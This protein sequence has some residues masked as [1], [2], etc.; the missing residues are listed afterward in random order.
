MSRV[1][2][3]IIKIPAGVQVTYADRVVTVTKVI[4]HYLVKFAHQLMWKFK[5]TKLKLLVET[6]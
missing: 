5:M 3:T 4:T 2:K 6:M 1:G